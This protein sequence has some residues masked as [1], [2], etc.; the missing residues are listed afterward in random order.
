MN[1]SDLI[2]IKVG[3]YFV[4]NKIEGLVSSLTLL[5]LVSPSLVFVRK[6]KLMPN[7]QNKTS[8]I[9]FP[10]N[11]LKMIGLLAHRKPNRFRHI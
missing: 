6:M 8:S 4:H 9:N 7:K 5:E 10:H 3:I 1:D 2:N 11:K